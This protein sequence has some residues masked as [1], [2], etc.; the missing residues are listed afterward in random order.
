MH[1]LEAEIKG[2]AGGLSGGGYDSEWHAMLDL[3][4][5]G[6]RSTFTGTGGLYAAIQRLARAHPKR[7]RWTKR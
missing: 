5:H 6:S 1:E 2:W 7:V 4:G 3:S